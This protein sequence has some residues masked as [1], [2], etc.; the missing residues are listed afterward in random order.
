MT[1]LSSALSPSLAANTLSNSSMMNDGCH[2]WIERYNAARLISTEASARGAKYEIKPN[3]VVLPHS[4]SALVT[5]RSGLCTA[6]SSCTQLNIVH[7]DEVREASW[8]QITCRR[9]RR[10]MSRNKESPSTG[11]GH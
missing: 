8:E 6:A 11:S 10:M 4:L 9:V 5:R 3:S 7:S 1:L 2:N